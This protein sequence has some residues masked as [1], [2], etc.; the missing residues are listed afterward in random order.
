M[1]ST[2]R[3]WYGCLS[4]VVELATCTS[5]YRIHC[6][7]CKT[8]LT[9]PCAKKLCYGVMLRE[10]MTSNAFAT[11]FVRAT[12]SL[13]CPRYSPSPY[14]V[15][16]VETAR[17]ARANEFHCIGCSVVTCNGFNGKVVF[18]FEPRIKT[19]YHKCDKMQSTAP[20]YC[21]WCKIS[22]DYQKGPFF[23]R[24]CNSSFCTKKCYYDCHGQMLVQY[25]NKQVQYYCNQSMHTRNMS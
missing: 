19:I 6:N 11:N 9:D 13:K 1:S 5:T 18:S 16:N 14:E 3:W 24:E 17:Q 23:C 12:R 15:F 7:D 4:C 22:G 21:E 10:Y 20:N 8:F 2:G 25:K